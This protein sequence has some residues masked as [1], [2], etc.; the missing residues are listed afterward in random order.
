MA[1]DQGGDTGQIAPPGVDQGIEAAAQNKAKKGD[2]ADHAAGPHL[3]EGA[4]D[5]ATGHD[6]AQTKKSA[7]Q[8]IGQG[9]GDSMG[10]G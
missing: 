8:Q 9:G 7:G 5:T 1:G 2:S 10:K 3:I 4:K 6:H